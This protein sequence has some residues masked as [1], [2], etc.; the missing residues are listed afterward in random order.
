MV[1][2]AVI[3]TGV[4]RCWSFPHKILK[5]AT[6]PPTHPQDDVTP[7]MSL[8]LAY[9]LCHTLYFSFQRRKQLG[10]LGHCREKSEAKSSLASVIALSSALAQGWCRGWGWGDDV[11]HRLCVASAPCSCTQ[12]MPEYILRIKSPETGA[13]SAFWATGFNV[14]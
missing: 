4:P 14:T 8:G 10:V 9:S 12:K 11:L 3:L 1:Q 5:T 7:W 2:L 13:F 6:S